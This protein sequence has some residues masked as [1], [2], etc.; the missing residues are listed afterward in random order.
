M[1]LARRMTR[2]RCVKG[3]EPNKT[4]YCKWTP[5]ITGTIDRDEYMIEP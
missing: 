1:Y 2:E 4:Q 3:S 5:D